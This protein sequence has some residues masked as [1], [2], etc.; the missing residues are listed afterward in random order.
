[1]AKQRGFTI[2]ELLIVSFII[3]LLAALTLT[4]LADSRQRS[5]DG[6]RLQETREIRSAL[7]LFYTNKNHYPRP[8]E[9]SEEE[10]VV[11]DRTDYVSEDLTAEDYFS[12]MPI[13][14]LQR[15]RYVYTYT[16][17]E[18]GSRFTLRFCLEREDECRELK[19]D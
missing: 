15:D 7:E 9:P 13:D 8:D 1:M 10:V 16:T 17:N 3:A 14:P 18:A 2:L 4:Y 19:S 6:K 12:V 11:I 5:R